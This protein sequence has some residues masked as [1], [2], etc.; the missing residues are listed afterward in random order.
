MIIKSINRP[1]LYQ[2]WLFKDFDETIYL[3]YITNIK[4]N[5]ITCIHF[6]KDFNIIHHIDIFNS[7]IWGTK[8]I[9]R[10]NLIEFIKQC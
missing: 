1:K 10:S 4:H 9:T 6:N 7:S 3:G 2:Y 8:T 5:E